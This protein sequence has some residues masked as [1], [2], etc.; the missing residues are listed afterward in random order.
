MLPS[1]NT[2]GSFTLLAPY[3]KT[4]TP[5]QE[6]TVVSI[7]SIGEMQASGEDPLNTIYLAYGATQAD[8]DN[9]LASRSSIVTFV[10][11]GN[12]YL[13]VPEAKVATDSNPSGVS[14]VERAILVNIGYLPTAIDLTLVT[15]LV[16]DA[17]YNSLGV[18]PGVE[19]VETSGTV[20]MDA[21]K[22]S[23]LD[24]TRTNVITVTKSYQTRYY[25]LLKLYNDQK[26][27][28]TN[29]EAIYAANGIG[30]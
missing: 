29:I 20:L 15:S 6:L 7:R 30:A 21:V 24:A 4:I 23:T 2:K 3:D 9:D 12:D 13:Y 10:T 25:D 8:F 18:A 26:A 1:I 16:T 17:V 27:F 19:V 5:G 11:A 14:Y 28:I 22:H